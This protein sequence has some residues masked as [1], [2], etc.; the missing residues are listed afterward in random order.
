MFNKKEIISIAIIILIISLSISIG[1]P[2]KLPMVFAFV[3]IAISFNVFAKKIS[4]F[5]LESEIDIGI[6]NFKRYGIKPKEHFKKPF[7]AGAFFPIIS[8][9]I[10]F[11]IQN[12]VWMASLVFEVKPSIYRAAKKHGLYTFS[13]VSEDHIGLIAASG[14]VINIILAITGYLIGFPEFSKINIYYAFFNILPISDLD[15]NKIFFGK[16]ILWSVLA[17]IIFIGLILSV[18]VI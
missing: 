9:I 6:W 2:L 11:P 10:F 8:K 12:L 15:G 3:L 5:Y 1:N 4:S 17:S 7:F 16:N 13:E 18:V 14:I